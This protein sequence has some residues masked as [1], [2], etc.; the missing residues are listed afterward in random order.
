MEKHEIAKESSLLLKGKL[1]NVWD[2]NGYYWY[3]LAKT[4]RNDVIAFDYKYIDERSK[5]DFLRE[6]LASHGVTYIYEY[7]WGTDNCI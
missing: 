4:K 1:G 3:P 6:V 2:I 5:I 7:A